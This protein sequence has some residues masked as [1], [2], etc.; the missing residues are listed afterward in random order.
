MDSSSNS[1][2]HWVRGLGKLGI[3]WPLEREKPAGSA[4]GKNLRPPMAQKRHKLYLPLIFCEHQDHH[5][6]QRNIMHHILLFGCL[7]CDNDRE[8]THNSFVLVICKI[9]AKV[10]CMTR[11][12]WLDFAHFCFGVGVLALHTPFGSK[13]DAP[14]PLFLPRIKKT[15]VS[16]GLF[17]QLMGP[18][19][20]VLFGVD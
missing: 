6:I 10:H 18:T 14:E 4:A 5:W 11:I 3:W 19:L 12:T 17:F 7:N 8:N 1:E 15:Y 2:S 16:N 13:T 9:T 20:G